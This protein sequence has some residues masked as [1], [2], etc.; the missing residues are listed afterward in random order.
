MILTKIT[1]AM[2]HDIVCL[3]D[4]AI[5][6]GVNRGIQTEAYILFDE[7]LQGLFLSQPLAD[8]LSV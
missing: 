3:L 1:P 6:T 2:L 7:G 5:A 4:T 8:N